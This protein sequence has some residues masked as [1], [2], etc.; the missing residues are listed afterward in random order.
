M[1][2]LGYDVRCSRNSNKTGHNSYSRSEAVPIAHFYAGQ[3]MWPHPRTGLGSTANPVITQC[4]EWSGGGSENK[5]LSS[6]HPSLVLPTGSR[7]RPLHPTPSLGRGPHWSPGGRRPG[8][9]PVGGG[10]CPPGPGYRPPHSPADSEGEEGEDTATV[11]LQRGQRAW[12]RAPQKD[13]GVGGPRGCRRRAPLTS[14]LPKE[15][16]HR[17]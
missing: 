6:L 17:K 5:H 1:V 12:R 2:Q 8:K 3:G 10:S 15:L 11:T 9:S 13:R 7:T 16:R 4:I 14:R